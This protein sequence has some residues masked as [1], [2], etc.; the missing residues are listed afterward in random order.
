MIFRLYILILDLYIINWTESWLNRCTK[1]LV[2]LNDYNCYHSLRS[3]RR[4]GGITVFIHD[5]FKV[6]LLSG[7][8]ESIAHFDSLSFTLTFKHA[9]LIMGVIYKPPQASFDLSMEQHF[10]SLYEQLSPNQRQA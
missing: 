1:E 8:T 2:S 6:E 7:S 3:D 9:I 4:G 10:L 5:T